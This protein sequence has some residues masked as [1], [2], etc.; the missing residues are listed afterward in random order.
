MYSEKFSTTAAIA[1]INVTN[2]QIEGMWMPCEYV[3][4][5][6]GRV[7]VVMLADIEFEGLATRAVWHDTVEEG[8]AHFF[9]TIRPCRKLAVR[10][11]V[12]GRP[13]EEWSFQQFLKRDLLVRSA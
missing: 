13:I 8:A 11:P 5:S 1:K 10:A 9:M 3:Q 6:T 4:G 2:V 7:R 12:A